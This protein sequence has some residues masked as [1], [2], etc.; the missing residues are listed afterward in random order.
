MKEASKAIS[1]HGCLDNLNDKANV[2]KCER[3]KGK[4]YDQSTV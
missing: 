3:E 4:N 1:A 2:E